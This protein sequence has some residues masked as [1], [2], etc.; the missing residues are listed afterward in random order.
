MTV[1]VLFV[2]DDLDLREAMQDTFVHLGG[3]TGVFAASLAEL[4][5]Q[6]PSALVCQL[7]I[8]DVNLGAGQPTGVDVVRWLRSRDFGGRIVFLT[9]HAA[10]DARVIAAAEVADTEILSKPLGGEALRALIDD[11]RSP[12]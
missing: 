1:P 5:A 10:G 4:Q 9:G 2:D 7:A 3:I 12:G 11:V 6:A 8:V